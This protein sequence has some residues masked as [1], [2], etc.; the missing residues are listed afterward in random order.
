MEDLQEDMG[1]RGPRGRL[2]NIAGDAGLTAF[3]DEL[4]GPADP[5]NTGDGTGSTIMAMVAEPA[6]AEA[7]LGV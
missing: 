7:V 1:N 6:V 4:A 2:A 3:V 5:T